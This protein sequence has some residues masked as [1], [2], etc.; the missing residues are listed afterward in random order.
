MT[1]GATLFCVAPAVYSRNLGQLDAAAP[2][3]CGGHVVLR[4]EA[5]AKIRQ[6]A[7]ADQIAD[8]RHGRVRLGQQRHRLMHAVVVDIGQ[9]ACPDELAE[10]RAE[11]AGRNEHALRQIIQTDV[12]LIFLVNDVQHLLDP[13][14]QNVIGILNDL[15]RHMF[16]LLNQS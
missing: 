2:V 14:A 1:A 12:L 7:I 3:L 4:L 9:K 13:C 6:I 5:G 15:D 11:V 8:V 16:S 10:Q